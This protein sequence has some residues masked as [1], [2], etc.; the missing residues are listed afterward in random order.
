ML[1]TPWG[2]GATPF[3]TLWDVRREMDRLFEGYGRPTET[4]WSMPTEVRETADELRFNIELPGLRP[5]D[6]DLT[7]EN[8]VLTIT[9]EK[10]FEREEGKDEDGNYTLFERRYGKFSRSFTLPSTVEAN[11]IKADFEHGVLSVSLP[12]SETA[13]PRRIQIGAGSGGKQI[14]AKK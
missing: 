6:I 13:K 14:S 11:A 5:E 8:N 2:R 4:S 9:A 12:K 7:V 1:P 10:K 3:D